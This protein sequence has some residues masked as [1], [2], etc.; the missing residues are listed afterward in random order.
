MHSR[1]RVEGNAPQAGAS[2]RPDARAVRAVDTAS[3]SE[4][5]RLNTQFPRM[6]RNQIPRAKYENRGED[7]K[8]RVFLGRHVTREREEVRCAHTIAREPWD[9]SDVPMG[10]NTPTAS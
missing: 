8:L 3:W 7:E 9:E 5:A 10:R 2:R 6:A 4:Q 1:D